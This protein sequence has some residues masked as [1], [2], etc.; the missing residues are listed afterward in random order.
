M[1][2]ENKVNQVLFQPDG[3]PYSATFN[4]IY[5]DTQDGCLQ[6]EQVFIQNN[7]IKDRLLS[8]LLPLTIA[9][10]GFGTGLNFFLTLALFQ[11]LNQSTDQ[12]TANTAALA[13]FNFISVE[14][15]PLTAEQIKQALLIW[16]ALTPFVTEFLKQYPNKLTTGDVIH[17]QFFNGKVNLQLII[18]D[19]ATGFA[20]LNV[21]KQ[22]LVD[23]WYLDGFAPASNPEMW[24][25]AL[26]SQ[27]ARLSKAEA[28][29]GT[30]T[31]AGNVRRGLNQVGF[32]LEKKLTAGKKKETLFG[33]FQQNAKWGK[34]YQIRQQ[35]IK[36]M[37]V[38]II[39]GGIASACAAYAL[40]KAGIN[41]TIYCQDNAIAQGASSNTIGALYPL[42]HQQP[43]DISLFYQQAFIRARGFYDE[44]LKAG[45]DFAHNWCGLLEVS[46]KEALEKR[47]QQ[48]EQFNAW[49]ESLIQSLSAKEASSVAKIPLSH[50]GLYMPNA[51]WISPPELVKAL[52]TAAQ[53]TKRLKIFTQTKINTIEQTAEEHWRLDTN[54]GKIKAQVLILCSGAETAKL[55][56]ADGLP[57]SSVRGQ[58]SNMAANNERVKNLDTVLCH[59]GYLTPQYQGIHC[60]GASFEKDRFDTEASIAEDEFNLTM[61]EKC[62][63]E[64]NT[65]QL[66]DVKSSKARLRCMTPDHL[67]VVGAMPKIAEHIACYAH[68]A[69]DKNWRYQTP[70]P[71]YKNLYLL[72][73]LGAR[74]LCSAP[75][76][77]DILTAELTNKPYPVDDKMLFNLAPNR[78]VIRDLIKRKVNS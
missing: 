17:M 68:L 29:L 18:N 36:P 31:I 3:S 25:A 74:G 62:L 21:A 20:G 57:L 5:F 76:L 69:K 50:G 1:T 45:F 49:P 26:F 32:R 13:G 23:A 78:F 48:F 70:A 55:S 35:I 66:N 34:A 53:A 7:K 19:A 16:P 30:F 61:L 42:I 71:V 14:K 65:W 60:I 8:A 46:Y 43:D 56:I 15:F 47:Q 72:T 38:S 77:A 73:G 24:S 51:G 52:F 59:K 54:K 39:G 41:V 63:P 67:P 6:S 12:S 2:S 10:T 64:L 27:M 11:T 9:E 37:R 58:V 44:L 4:D 40:T 75:L 33:I 28:T 22:G